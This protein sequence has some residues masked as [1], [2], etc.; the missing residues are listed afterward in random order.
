[1]REISRGSMGGRKGKEEDKG[2]LDRE[3]VSN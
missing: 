3:S 2:N 1:M